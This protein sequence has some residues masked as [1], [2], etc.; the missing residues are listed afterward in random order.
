MKQLRGCTY[1]SPID[2]IGKIRI[3]AD[4]GRLCFLDFG[5]K[6]GRIQKLLKRRYDA[7][8]IIE[9]ADVLNIRSRLARY[10]E[11]DWS[12][13]DDLIPTQIVTAGSDFQRQVWAQ[14][15]T[16]PAG[17]TIS[18]SE[19]ATAI[20]RPKAIRAV[21]QANANNP[22][23]IIVPC[24]RVIGKNSA[25]RGYAGGTARQGTLLK[26]EGVL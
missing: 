12:A 20:S 23:S 14:L 15:M 22:L 2:E 10:F 16:I 3:I 8:D 4:G 6:D 26:H 1:Q 7:F 24:H 9:E 25:L 18:Y 19:L 5:D 21:G 17:T 13:F 11:R